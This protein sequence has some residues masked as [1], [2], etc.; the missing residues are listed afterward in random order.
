MR[1]AAILLVIYLHAYF[2]PW[3]V[4]PGSE[5]LALHVT[6]LFANSSV[7]V[8]LFISGYLLAR[9]SSRDV[10]QYAA[11]RAR[12]IVL[13]MAVCMTAILA[14]TAWQAG[15]LDRSMLR[16]F[17]LFDISGQYYYLAVLLILTVAA[18]P[19]RRWDARRLAWLAA[20]AF[21]ANLAMV[22][23]YQVHGLGDANGAELAYRNPLMWVFA[24]DFGLAVARARGTPLWGARAVAAATVGMVAV[25]AVYLAH[26]LATGDYPVSYF[27]VTV[28][29]FSSL[30]LIVYPAAVAGLG[31]LR[32]GRAVL[33]PFRA[34]APYAFAIYLLHKPFFIGVLSDRVVSHSVL[35][36]DFMQLMLG[37]FVVGGSGAILFV[38]AVARIGGPRVR[39][40]IGVDPPRA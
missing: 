24:Y 37:L 13:P 19:V 29:L 32:A 3:A 18:Y 36:G 1:G 33:A 35:A 11:R 8:F 27:G 40:L 26:G 34:L 17:A 14:W 9:D 7:P 5:L 10:L 15:G 2:S 21:V 4:T 39:A 28:F 6:H 12:R 23:W 16:S 25:F 31:R 38:V 20:A 30:S 22:T